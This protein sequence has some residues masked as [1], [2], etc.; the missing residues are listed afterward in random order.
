MHQAV[1]PSIVNTSCLANKQQTYNLDE[2][3]T[4][5]AIKQP[6]GRGLGFRVEEGD[7]KVWGSWEALRV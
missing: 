2:E 4:S 7:N 3:E 6:A 1:Y 5:Y